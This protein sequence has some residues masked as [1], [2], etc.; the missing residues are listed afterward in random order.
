MNL[1]W[2]ELSSL[3]IFNLDANYNVND[4]NG[5]DTQ[6]RYEDV[7]AVYTEQVF[8]KYY[9]GLSTSV[10]AKMRSDFGVSSN[11]ALKSKIYSLCGAAQ[12]TID[13]V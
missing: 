12:T 8:N 4:V 9:T 7:K 13:E 2:F 10:D 3:L 1:E 6:C 11:A 5:N